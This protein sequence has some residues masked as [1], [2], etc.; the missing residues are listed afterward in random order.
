LKDR[1]FSD[2][3]QTFSETILPMIDEFNIK[4]TGIVNKITDWIKENPK[5]AQTI[6]A[7]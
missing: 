1:A 6:V 3:Y 4:I 5:L 7:I 2:L